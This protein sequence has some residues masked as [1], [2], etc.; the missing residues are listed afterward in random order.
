MIRIALVIDTL[1]GV[2]GEGFAIDFGN[3][4]PEARRFD[5]SWEPN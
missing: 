1:Q 3:V 2:H 5:E 4:G